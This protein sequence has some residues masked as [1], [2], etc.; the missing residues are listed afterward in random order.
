LYVYK[1]SKI[2]L[3]LAV[4]Y[5]VD[6]ERAINKDRLMAHIEQHRGKDLQYPVLGYA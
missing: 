4:L 5:T 2:S 3:A 6:T 1:C